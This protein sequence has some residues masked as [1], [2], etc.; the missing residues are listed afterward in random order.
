[1]EGDQFYPP[2][3]GGNVRRVSRPRR[4][5]RAQPADRRQRRHRAG[6]R[7]AALS[8][9]HAAAGKDRR[10][11][12][13]R[14]LCIAGPA[15]SA[16]PTTRAMCRTASCRRSC[17]DRLDHELSVINKLGFPNYFLIV[18]DFVRYAREQGIPATARGTGVGS[19]VC[20][21][22]VS[23]PRL[24]AASTTCCSSGSSI[25]SRTRSARYRHRLLQGPPRRGH[26]VR[27]GQVRRGERRPDRHVRH[28]GRPGGDS[29][30]RPRA[31]HAAL[32]RRSDRGDGARRAGHHARRGARSR[33]PT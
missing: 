5:R 11:D 17:I 13:L 1:M 3:P 14:E 27:Q 31:G 20:L 16:T 22:A 18:W 23:E 30:R 9:L 19:L 25:E 32:P 21:R 10:S 15:T 4:R 8:H 12:Y 24:P 6:A 33:A 28:A 26:P 2:Q 7:Q 29:R